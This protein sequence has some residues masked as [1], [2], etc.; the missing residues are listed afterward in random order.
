[1]FYHVVLMQFTPEADQ[2]FFDR[3]EHYIRRIRDECADMPVYFLASN[4]AVR[5]DGLTHGIVG[6]FQ[7]SAAHDSYQVSPA[8]QEMKAFMSPFIHRITVLDGEPSS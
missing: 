8:H 2:A 6:A 5:S 1:M 3:V 7:S 4:V